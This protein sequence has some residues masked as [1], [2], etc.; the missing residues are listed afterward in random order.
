MGGEATDVKWQ[1]KPAER[2]TKKNILIFGLE[3]RKAGGYFDTLGAVL[4]FLRD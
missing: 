4:K 3:E 2:H 1:S